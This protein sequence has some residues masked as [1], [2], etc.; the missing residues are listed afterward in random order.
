M[1]FSAA[2]ILAAAI[3]ASAH[4]SHHAHR[5]AHRSAAAGVEAREFVMNKKPAP[6]APS[7]TTPPPP[8]PAPTTTATPTPSKAPAPVANAAA[9]VDSSSSSTSSTSSSASAS[10]SSS[11]SSGFEPFCSGGNSKRAT[12]AQIAYAGNTGNG[13]YGCNMKEVSA[14][15]VGSYK[16]TASFSNNLGKDQVCVCWNKIG[17]KGLI[18]G[19]FLQNVPLKFNL[20]ASGESHV[21]FD[22]NT[23]G[24]CACYPGSIPTTTFGQVASTWLEFDCGNTSNDKWNGFDVSALVSAKYGLDIPPMKACVGDV[25][26]T[27]FQGGEGHNAYVAGTEDLDGIGGNIPGPDMAMK[28]TVG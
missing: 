12:L 19:F 10:S 23:Q 3:G 22:G 27:I 21:A 17:P 5:N 4:P 25:C 9:A 14:S 26:S 24:G 16:C 2:V 20:P 7:S 6:P 11:G 13:A 18:D 8:P 15:A 28:V 1:K